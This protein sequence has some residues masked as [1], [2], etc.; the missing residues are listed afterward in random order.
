MKL[1]PLLAGLLVII[2]SSCTLITSTNVPGTTVGKTPKTL[3][4]KYELQYPSEFAALMEGGS[5]T[6]TYVTL[7]SDR[8]TVSS[9]DGDNVSML[10]DSLFFSTIK[11]QTYL[12]MGAPPSLIVFKVVKSGK[13]INLY[14]MFANESANTASLSPYFSQVTEVPG[15]PGEDGEPGASTFEVRIDDSKLENFFKSEQAMKDPFVLKKVK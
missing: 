4:G 2:L 1:F 15:E 9:A 7:A 8:M 12:S 5:D 3:L 6:K 10:G 11:K 14:P 13:N